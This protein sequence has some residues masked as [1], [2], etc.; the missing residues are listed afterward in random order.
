MSLRQSLLA[1][2]EETKGQAVPF[3]LLEGEEAT[4]AV[5]EEYIS[6]SPAPKIRKRDLEETSEGALYLK[7]TKNDS[8][9]LVDVNQMFS[10][11]PRR[12]LLSLLNNEP[13]E[14]TANIASEIAVLAFLCKTTKEVEDLSPK[15]A[16][17][18]DVCDLCFLFT[19]HYISVYDGLKCDEAWLG[20]SRKLF[21]ALES[22]QDQLEPSLAIGERLKNED[23]GNSLMNILC[24][25]ASLWRVP[26]QHRITGN[27]KKDLSELSQLVLSVFIMAIRFC[28]SFSHSFRST[29]DFLSGRVLRALVTLGGVT[30]DSLLSCLG[31]QAVH[32][33]LLCDEAGMMEYFASTEF[34]PLA[35]PVAKQAAEIARTI[36]NEKH[37]GGAVFPTCLSCIHLWASKRAFRDIFAEV[38]LRP[39][40]RFLSKSQDDFEAYMRTESSEGVVACARTLVTLAGS[41]DGAPDIVGLQRLISTL[42]H[43]GPHATLCTLKNISHLLTR[44]SKDDPAVEQ[45]EDVVDELRSLLDIVAIKLVQCGMKAVEPAQQ[46]RRDCEPQSPGKVKAGRIEKKTGRVKGSSKKKHRK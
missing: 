18:Q 7:V 1:L 29:D 28:P 12:L 27:A 14:L 23:V 41:C 15:I 32:E 20:C 24:G 25:V 33:I 19:Q 3:P 2:Q 31:W 5:Y 26:K 16:T 8:Q 9:A 35:A 39:C 38:L 34:Y 6:D 43:M 30:S 45:M 36:L 22:L 37:L 11:I 40:L 4:T 42:I 44:A 13:L 21:E 46:Y 10:S 17:S